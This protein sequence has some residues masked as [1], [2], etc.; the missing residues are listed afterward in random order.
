MGGAAVVAPADALPRLATDALVLEAERGRGGMGRVFRARD[1]RLGRAVAV[2]VLRPESAANPDF[3]ARFAREARTLARLEHSGIVSV[4]DFGTTPEGDGY[5]VM[6]LVSGGSIADRLPLPVRDALA[7]A[8]A[9]CAALAYAH[10]RGIIHRDIKPAN[11]L[12]GAG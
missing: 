12:C 11:D 4:H 10:G 3:R 9:L 1:D 6:Q 2:K 7:I 8:S 5:L